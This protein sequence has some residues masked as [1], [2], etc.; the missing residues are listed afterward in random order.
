MSIFGWARRPRV[1]A[2]IAEGKDGRFH[3]S[4]RDKHGDLIAESAP[5]G[6]GTHAA[7]V[8][9]AELLADAKIIVKGD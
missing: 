2:T 9:L 4:Y 7:A 8:E 1:T 6:T 3:T 5:R